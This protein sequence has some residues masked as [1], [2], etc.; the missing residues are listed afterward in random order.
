[1]GCVCFSFSLLV[2]R[3]IL[4]IHCTRQKMYTCS[5]AHIGSMVLGM[6]TAMDTVDLI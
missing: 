3:Q 5:Y 1:M 4:C 2:L 6:C